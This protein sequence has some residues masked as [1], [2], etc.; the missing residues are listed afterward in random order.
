M[1][2]LIKA[3]IK[4]AQVKKRLQ[5]ALNAL[6][7]HRGRKNEISMLEYACNLIEN[8]VAKGSHIDKLE[9]LYEVMDLVFDKLTD[10]EKV[11]IKKNVNYLLASGAIKRDK[12]RK[13]LWKFCKSFL[14]GR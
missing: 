9:L 1:A 12:F 7:E 8:N 14:D 6:P 3:D 2:S 13:R 5:D 11:N 10:I 4:K